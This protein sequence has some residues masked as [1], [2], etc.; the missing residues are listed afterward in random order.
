MTSDRPRWLDNLT[1]DIR[2]AL[3]GL[4]RSRVFATTAVLTLALGIGAN[5][6]MFGAIDQLMFQPFP[7]LRDPGSVNRVYI[8]TTSRGRLI[9]RSRFQYTRYLDLRKWTTSFSEWGAFAEWQ[10]AIGQGDA[11]RERP[12][13]GPQQRVLPFLRRAAGAQGGTSPRWKTRF[14]GGRTSPC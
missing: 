7:R 10:L 4:G 13:G 11:T 9:T 6:A 1:Q 12:G 2:Y 8:E 3:R 5:V 14:R